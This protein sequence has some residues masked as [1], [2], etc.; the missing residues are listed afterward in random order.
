MDS[1]GLGAVPLRS[2]GERMLPHMCVWDDIEI[3]G[4]MPKW[5]LIFE[6]ILHFLPL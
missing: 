3:N 5:D 2:D 6:R 4:K 1:L